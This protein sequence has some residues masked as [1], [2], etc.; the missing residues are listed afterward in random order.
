MKMSDELEKRARIESL[1]EGKVPVELPKGKLVVLIGSWIIFFTIG[2]ACLFDILGPQAATLIALF[3]LGGILIA[4]FIVPL[5]ILIFVAGGTII[6]TVWLLVRLLR[7]HGYGLLKFSMIVQIIL[8]WVFF[9]ITFVLVGTFDITVILL[10]VIAII[11]TVFTILYFTI[12]KTRMELAGAILTLTGKVT[13]EEKELFVPGYLKVF[14][15]GILSAFGSC[16][17]LDI[18]AH[19]IPAT[20]ALWFHYIPIILFSF[21][22]FLYLYVN[23]FFFNAITIEITY[24]WYRKKDPTFKDGLTIATYQL[25][26]LALFAVFSSIIRVI[27]MLLRAAASKSKTKSPWMGG[28]F[29]LADGIIG[30]VW[31]YVNY[32]TLPSIV[33]EDVPATTAIKRSAHRLFD[34]WVDVLL[35]EWGVSSVFTMLQFL[36]I[37]V[38]ALGGGLLGFLLWFLFALSADYLLVMVIIGVILFL[39]LSMLVSKPVLN[40][41]NDIYLTFL[42]GHVIDRE[43]GYKYPN[44]LPA[45]LNNKMKDW[46]MA[47]PAV[48]RCQQCFTKVSQGD[49]T[50]PKCGAPLH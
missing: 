18:I 40:L 12:W 23:T 8:V 17:G 25:P 10:L 5:L 2:V 13:S 45:D 15:V 38:F 6:F 33:V 20:G 32:F 27:R 16:M 43:S 3:Q 19:T 1:L 14:F 50:C 44:N 47:H 36:I 7:K 11:T 28:G 34:N 41:F 48:R 4:Q 37:L 29:R 46:F 21:V 39:F 31:F 49:R 24:I 22:L 9:I 42:F 30:T 35:K 26:D